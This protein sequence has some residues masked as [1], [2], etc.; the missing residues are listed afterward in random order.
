MTEELA[1]AHLVSTWASRVL[2]GDA[3]AVARAVAVAERTYAGGASVGEAFA[4]GRRFLASW[5]RHPSHRP[6]RLPHALPAA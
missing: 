2:P 4:E 3:D 1:V 5:Q 6:R